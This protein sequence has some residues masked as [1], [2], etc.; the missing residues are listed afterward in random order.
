[1][2]VAPEGVAVGVLVE[3]AVGVTTK[4]EVGGSVVAV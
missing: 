1:M 3:E 2:L 4:V